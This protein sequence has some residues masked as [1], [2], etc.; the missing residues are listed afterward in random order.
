MIMLHFGTVLLK[1]LGRREQ[2]RDISKKLLVA[3]LDRHI[4]KPALEIGVI[5]A[6]LPL[7]YPLENPGTYFTGGWCASEPM[8]TERKL[9]ATGIR[10]PVRP[11]R[12]P[13][14]V[15]ITSS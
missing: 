4:R 3:Q 5:N 13:V 8:L 6:T 12:S 14:A 15:P 11:T 10:S 9:T 7:L 1:Y 2:K